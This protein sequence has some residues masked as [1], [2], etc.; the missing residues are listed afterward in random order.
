MY[1]LIIVL[2][3]LTAF[4]VSIEGSQ[5]RHKRFL[6]LSKLLMAALKSFR[7]DDV[8]KRFSGASSDCGWCINDCM[9][10]GLPVKTCGS[11]SPCQCGL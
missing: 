11:S 2:L 6:T 5:S 3:F 1:R 10:K 4:S 7:T 8:T 9:M